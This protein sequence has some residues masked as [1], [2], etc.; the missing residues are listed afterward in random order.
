MLVFCFGL[1]ITMVVRVARW[2]GVDVQRPERDNGVVALSQFDVLNAIDLLSS[3]AGSNATRAEIAAFQCS[4]PV[5]VGAPLAAAIS[6]GQVR[7]TQARSGGGA[8][9]L[10]EPGVVALEQERNGIPSRS[11]LTDAG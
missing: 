5:E 11:V 10:T 1:R 2:T 7:G 6:T 3:D 4:D 8:Y 9:A